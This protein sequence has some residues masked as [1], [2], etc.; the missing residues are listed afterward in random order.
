[1]EVLLALGKLIAL[2]IVL[3]ILSVAGLTGFLRGSK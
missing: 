1:M 2:G 3:G